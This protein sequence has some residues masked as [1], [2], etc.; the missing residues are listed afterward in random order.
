MDRLIHYLIEFN[1]WFKSL[2]C[3][4]QYEWFGT[5]NRE[6]KVIPPICE[7]DHEMYR[8]S[9]CFK[10][11]NVYKKTHKFINEKRTF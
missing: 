3:K 9:N 8:C 4:H 5:V 11:K 7:F 2:Y 10:I 6:L 1:F